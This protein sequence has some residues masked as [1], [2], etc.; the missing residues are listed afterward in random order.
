MSRLNHRHSG[1][2]RF[3]DE[4]PFRFAIDRGHRQKVDRLQE[5]EFALP[6]DFAQQ[7]DGIPAAGGF[8]LAQGIGDVLS[9]LRPAPAGDPKLG[10]FHARPFAQEGEGVAKDV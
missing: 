1:G 8:E 9:M 4:Q 3:E 2:E 10:V 5:I 6:V 7:A